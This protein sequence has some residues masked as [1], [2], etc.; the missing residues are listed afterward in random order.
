MTQSLTPPKKSLDAKLARLLA[1]PG[2]RDFILADAKD[3]DMAFGLAAPGLAAGGQPGSGPFRS[4]AELR[5]HI[6]ELVAEGLVDVMLMSGS[7]SDV[8]AVEEG[9]F[10]DS[11]VTPA[12]RMNDTTDI[13]LAAG[14]GTYPSQPALP[15]STTT[16]PHAQWGRLEPPREG[17]PAVDLGL[18]SLT[19]NG[20]AAA[21]RAMLSAYRDFRHEAER[22]GF[23]H[24]LEVF[25]PNALAQAGVAAP[26]G[27]DRFVADHVVR[28]LA[29]RHSDEQILVIGQYLDQI[30]IIA[31]AL[32]APKI[33][34]ATPVDEREQLYQAFREGTVPLL[35]VSKVANFSVDLPDASVAIQV[36]GS[37][38]SRQEEAQRLGRLLRPKSNGH[39]ASFYTLIAR[40]TVDQ[41]FAQNRQRFL[42][43]QGYSYTILDADDLLAATR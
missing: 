17:R 8:L 19:L 43:E 13:W 16:I 40:D 11:P 32:G 42:A 12:V 39:T 4:I 21:D 31:E 10:A 18:F 30:D 25:F 27:V 9:L 20:E 7:T 23:R 34:G 1:D 37:F 41:D 5:D 24:F 38:G 36:S 14:T 33:T 6:R 26:R 28:A 22:A 2:C 15:F 3:A 29:A 35:V